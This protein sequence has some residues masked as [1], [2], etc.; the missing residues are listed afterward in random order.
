MRYITMSIAALALVMTSCSESFLDRLLDERIEIDNEEIIT[1]YPTGSYAWIGEISSDNIMD[2]NAPHYPASPNVEQVLTHYN[3]S[4]YDRVDDE[5][6]RF[7]PAKSST[8]QDTPGFLWE[9]MYGAIASVNHALQAIDEI[10]DNGRNMTPSLTASRAEALLIRAYCHF[11]LVNVFSQAYKT[12]ELSR[13]DI[14]IPYMTE[15]EE[16]VI[17]EYNRG[18]VTDTYA[19]IQADLEEGLPLLDDDYASPKYHFNRKAAYAFASRFYLYA[20]KW[21]QCIKYANLCLG[22]APQSMLRDWV[23]YA[24]LAT[25]GTARPLNYVSTEN[26]CNLLMTACY[27]RLGTMFLNYNSYKHFAHGQYINGN[28]T[29]GAAHIW[30]EGKNAY[31]DGG[32]SYYPSGN[33]LGYCVARRCPY[34]F[35]TT[36]PVAGTGYY[37]TIFPAFTADDC[38][39]ERAEA[40]IHLKQY[41]KACEDM[42][43]W[44]HNYTTNE[45]LILTPDTIQKFYSKVGYCY[46]ITEEDQT[47]M[48]ST[49]KKHLH[50]VGFTI[51]AEG[52]VDE[53]MYQCL[54]DMRRIETIHRGMRWFDIKR[55]GMEI[56]RR[57][58]ENHVPG[59]LVDV[60]TVDDERKAI[61]VP[62]QARDAGVTP[63]PR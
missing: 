24:E 37:R 35:E 50:P 56:K 2:N 52:S 13:N 48:V 6:F 38:L 58:M 27:S 10:S 54:L 42:N 45:T 55:F 46:E 36:D 32:T 61:Q 19:K 34:L 16:K 41:D 18:T 15:P 40:Y 43:L 4:P 7:E 44:M 28:E 33:D 26:N 53:C 1:C 23:A 12:D 8:N 51:E 25:S 57:M 3:L 11:V 39:L 21:D 60:L 5:M 14:G 30:G 20:G 22:E 49:I 31:K 29:F 17:V 47:G 59:R 62:Q 63:N 9:T